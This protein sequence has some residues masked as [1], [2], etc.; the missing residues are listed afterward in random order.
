MLV[1]IGQVLNE[2][3]LNIALAGQFG[4]WLPDAEARGIRIRHS[5]GRRS[6]RV[7]RSIDRAHEWLRWHGRGR[8]LVPLFDAWWGSFWLNHVPSV[9][10]G[11]FGPSSA[12]AWQQNLMDIYALQ[13]W[14]V[15]ASLS[16]ALTEDFTH[17]YLTTASSYVR[18]SQLMTAVESLPLTGVY[19]GTAHVDAI[20]GSQ[21]ASG[22]SR[23]LSRD[24]V[25]A[26][27]REKLRYRNDIMEDAGLGRL[28][29]DLGI[30]MVPLPSINVPSVG[31]LDD[32]S[33]GEILENFHFRTTSRSNGSRKDV[34]V[35]KALHS[36]VTRLEAQE[37]R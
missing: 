20:S 6:N 3:W 31:S 26:V 8:S 15:L 25:E 17:L 22:A 35:M 13:R 34:Q 36:R 1:V 19:A 10:L 33:D 32:L 28:T 5:H 29:S 4:T 21:F 37:G 12:V 9:T 23:V 11:S 16:Q 2:P 30:E 24:V 27:V 18:V 7:V 14:K